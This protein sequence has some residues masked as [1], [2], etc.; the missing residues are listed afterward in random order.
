[1][2]DAAASAAPVAA[3][4]SK[5]EAPATAGEAPS[6]KGTK[7]KVKVNGLESDVDYDELVSSY[8][9]RKASDERFQQAKKM[10]DQADLTKRELAEFTK[11]P[12]KFAAKHNVDPYQLA[13][14]LLLQKLEYEQMPESDRKLLAAEQRSKQLEA[15]LETRTK[16]EREAAQT[17]A[18]AKAAQEI[19]E[20]ISA[21]LNELGRKPTPRFIARMAES[22]LAHLESQDGERPDAKS[23]LRKVNSEYATDVAEYLE[24]L[25]E[26]Q[27]LTALPQK[28]RDALRKAEVKH[29]MSQDPVKSRHEKRDAPQKQVNVKRM[30]TDHYFQKLDKKFGA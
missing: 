21:A 26:D 11:D 20:E 5:I 12:F 7:H 3:D 25:P 22:M 10:S 2:T 28:I 19:D 27:L 8:Q 18:Q 6:F 17:Q 9:L 30:P 1:M 16:S 24:N 4:A 23:V 13:E 14:T 29:V 15:E